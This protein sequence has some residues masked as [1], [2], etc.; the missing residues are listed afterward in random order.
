MKPVNL[1]EYAFGKDDGSLPAIYFDDLTSNEVVDIY[2][3]LRSISSVAPEDKTVWDTALE[4]DVALNAISDP[5]KDLVLGRIE[6]FSHYL[7]GLK[8]QGV[9]IVDLSIFVFTNSI[10]LFYRMGEHWAKDQ[11][12]AVFSLTAHLK[13]MCATPDVYLGDASGDKIQEN[14]LVEF[15]KCITNA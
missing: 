4:K 5:G 1:Y 12:E 7:D 14:Y 8:F 10:E 13:K 15:Y 2:R 3:Y 11:I 9:V 6:P